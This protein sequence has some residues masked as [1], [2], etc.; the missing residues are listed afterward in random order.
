MKWLGRCVLLLAVVAC[1]YGPAAA[2]G[3]VPE[4]EDFITNL[5]E[6][7]IDTLT[8]DDMAAQERESRFRTL[9]A[10]NFDVPRIGN[11]V[12][13]VYAR[14]ATQEELSSFYDVF[15]DLLVTTY[16]GRFEEYSGEGFTVL[17]SF[18]DGNDGAVVLSEITGRNGERIRQERR[19]ATGHRGAL[20]P[21]AGATVPA[22][23][24]EAA[25]PLAG[26]ARTGTD[27]S[28]GASPVVPATQPG[29]TW[30]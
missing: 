26:P 5:G 13:A 20:A 2:E 30:R 21:V 8:G 29:P 22:P 6:E 11:R 23:D 4:A 19:R 7:A 1:G 18:P 24:P 25:D 27:P 15:E 17:R 14:Q 10:G 9:L 3:N 16:I 28:A 12:L